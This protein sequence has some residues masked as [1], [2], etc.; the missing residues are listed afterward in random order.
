MSRPFSRAQDDAASRADPAAACLARVALRLTP[1]MADLPE[2]A[3]L[4]F[5]PCGGGFA[6]LGIL[7]FAPLPGDGFHPCG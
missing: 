7:E 1:V 5:A 6:V 2:G 4:V 3:A